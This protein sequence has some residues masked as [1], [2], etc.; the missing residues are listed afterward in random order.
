MVMAE[1]CEVDSTSNTK[2]GSS[3]GKSI[4]VKGVGLGGAVTTT[5]LYQQS[6]LVSRPP[7]GAR[8]IQIPVGFGRR[9]M[10]AIASKNY[11]VDVSV[12][13]G[14]TEIFSTT[15]D[16]KT[17]KAEICAGNDGLI[18]F[19]NTSKSLKGV[20]DAQNQALKTF[21]T[22]SSS[23]TTAPQIAAAAATLLTSLAQTDA[24]ISALLKE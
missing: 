3:P 5:E 1:L 8:I 19:K 10:I 22:T 2:K 23:A 20:L 21:A 17:V 6:G 7:K 14:E 13:E 11:S 18:K 16:G 12:N 4:V 24:D 15:A 9:L